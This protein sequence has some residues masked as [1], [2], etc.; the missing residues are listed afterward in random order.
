MIL[1]GVGPGAEGYFSRW[2][3]IGGQS[4]KTYEFEYAARLITR[5]D[6][7]WNTTFVADQSNSWYSR[8]DRPSYPNGLRQF[9]LEATLYDMWGR[10][11]LTD[12][13]ELSS[14]G[15]IPEEF[16]SQFDVNDDGYVVWV[17]EGN[18]WRD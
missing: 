11:L 13:S 14:K 8:W 7:S 4:G 18:T 15:Q 3:N 17:G 2:D 5:P 1:Q 10:Y 6:L 16:H 12:R 9:G